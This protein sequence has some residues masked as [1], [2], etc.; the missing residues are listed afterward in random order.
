MIICGRNPVMKLISSSVC[1]FKNLKKGF[2]TCDVKCYTSTMNFKVWKV[3]RLETKFIY[4]YTLIYTF[5]VKGTVK[6]SLHS[7]NFIQN[8]W[9]TRTKNVGY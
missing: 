7:V 6:L 1:S 2:K 8:I 5:R 9:E 4:I 3:Y